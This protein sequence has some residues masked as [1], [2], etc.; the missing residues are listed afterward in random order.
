M[1][2]DLCNASA[3]FQRAMNNILRSYLDKFCMIYL[4]DI[5]I[6]SK[7]KMKQTLTKESFLCHVDSKKKFVMN[8]DASNDCIK[9]VI[10]QYHSNAKDK[11]ILHSVAY[12]LK[13]FNHIQRNYSTQK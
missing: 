3:S 13:K 10:Q 9:E 1:S 5:L 8:V 11:M 12:I 2:F 7:T 4:D 6:Y